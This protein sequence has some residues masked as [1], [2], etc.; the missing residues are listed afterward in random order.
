MDQ[1]TGEDLNPN[2]R[3]NV[4]PDGGDEVTMRNPDRPSN[5]NLGHAPE[6]EQDDTLERKRLTKI[7]DPEKWEIK[8]VGI[9][10]MNMC[11][12]CFVYLFPSTLMLHVC[13]QMIA[14][15]VL[16]KEEFPDFDDET[17]ILP[18]VD[19]EEGKK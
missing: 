12:S 3:R 18:K 8:Q 9:Y 4:G 1:E 14:A 10:S 6:L 16:S 17:G 5:L 7:S 13:L 11:R 19:D 15:N 2:R